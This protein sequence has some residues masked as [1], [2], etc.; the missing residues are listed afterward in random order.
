MLVKEFSKFGLYN[1]TICKC[2]L[3]TNGNL[4]CQW[5]NLTSTFGL[6]T[7]KAYL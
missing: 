4:S 6:V 3:V 5:L 2:L 1:Q 7:L